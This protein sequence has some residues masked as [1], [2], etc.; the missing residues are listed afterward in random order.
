MHFPT[1]IDPGHTQDISRSDPDYYVG[2]WAYDDP[3]STLMGMMVKLTH[4]TKSHNLWYAL[5]V[6]G[7]PSHH[8]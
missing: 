8:C 3:V 2:Q 5:S 6:F 4:N 7:L 1:L